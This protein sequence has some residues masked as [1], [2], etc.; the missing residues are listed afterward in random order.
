MAALLSHI[1][2][3]GSVGLKRDDREL[4]EAHRTPSVLQRLHPATL[5]QLAQTLGPP[6]SPGSPGQT[7]R[8]VGAGFVLNLRRLQ[9][10]KLPPCRRPQ[11]VTYQ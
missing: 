1:S 10:E 9:R 8:G 11:A 6:A 5:P 4:S 3:A 7:Y 2:Q